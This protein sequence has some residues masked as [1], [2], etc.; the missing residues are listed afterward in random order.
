MSRTIYAMFGDHAAAERAAG[1]LMDH[2]VPA[3]RISLLGR[4]GAEPPPTRFDVEHRSVTADDRQVE[5]GSV[6]QVDLADMPG[7]SAHPILDRD[8]SERA[9]TYTDPEKASAVRDTVE[10]FRPA[11]GETRPDPE[12]RVHTGD[13]ASLNATH[14]ITTTTG[15]DAAA[16]AAKGAGL[17][18]GIGALAAV[19][20]LAIPGIGVVI[21]GGAL[22]S[23]LAGAAAATAAGAVA[24]GAWGYLKDQGIP[25]EAAE[26]YEAHVSGG[27]SVLSVDVDGA[28]VDEETVREM[29][30]KYGAS[31]MDS[32]LH[33][34]ARAA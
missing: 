7:R 16:G 8:Y 2:G 25:T 23:A 32:H 22:A 29:L 4:D 18:L 28:E 14:G 34:Q 30:A 27:G 1:A 3:N 12:E 17:G 5:G 6:T 11:W 26:R 13:G 31:G 9:P 33:I 19:A 21:G 15:E 24:G 20:S 10:E